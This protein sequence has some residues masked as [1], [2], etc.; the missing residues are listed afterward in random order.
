[1]YTS[2]EARK[3][4]AAMRH[5]IKNAERIVKETRAGGD[6]Q[7]YKLAMSAYFSVLDKSVKV[8]VTKRQTADR[9]KSRAALKPLQKA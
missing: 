3:T 8:G 1:M 9:K 2:E 5:K 6:A 7:K 4:N